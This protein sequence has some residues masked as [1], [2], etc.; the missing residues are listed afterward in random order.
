MVV[1]M[2]EL[3][4]LQAENTRLRETIGKM[5]A[6]QIEMALDCYIDLRDKYGSDHPGLQPLREQLRRINVAIAADH[7]ALEEYCPVCAYRRATT[8]IVCEPCRAAMRQQE[9]E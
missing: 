3:E 5:A 8:D 9:E 2:S 7:V 4:R 1:L 6:R